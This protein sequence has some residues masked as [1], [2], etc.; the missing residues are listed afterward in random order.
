MLKATQPDQR[1]AQSR[2]DDGPDEGARHGARKGEVIIHIGEAGGDIMGGCAIDE[3]IVGGLK[4]ERLLY[5]CMRRQQ[6]VKERYD[7][8]DG[9][10]LKICGL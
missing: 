6:Q 4:I 10:Q 5:L 8:E 1:L 7:D 9:G 2:E 3:Y